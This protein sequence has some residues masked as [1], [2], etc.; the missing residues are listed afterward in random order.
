MTKTSRQAPQM[1]S[2]AVSAGR[3]ECAGH[4]VFALGHT[5]RIVTAGSAEI[6]V[7]MLVQLAAVA[8]VL[9]GFIRPELYQGA[10]IASGVLWSSAFVVFV[11]RYW[12]IL[13][14]PRVDGR[15]G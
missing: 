1:T 6:A 4:P 13:T 12:P 11:F 5:G 8:R 15:P 10:V 7:F 2:K 14:R 9:S 3:F